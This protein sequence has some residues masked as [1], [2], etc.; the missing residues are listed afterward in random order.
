MTLAVAHREDERVVLDL[1][2]ERRPPFSP[3]DVVKE[4]TE[5]LRRYAITSVHGDRYGGEWPRERFDAHGITYE[6][7][8]LPKSELYRE[9][10]PLLNSGQVEL[11]DHQ[12]LLA[13]LLRLE[14]RTARGGRD[15]IDHAPGGHDDVAN[16]VAGALVGAPAFSARTDFVLAGGNRVAWPFGMEPQTARRGLII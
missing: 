5:T 1:V 12:R 3:E 2:R 11:L 14:R 16:A 10:L 4:F 7:A 13:Q 6:V 9:L 8:E 15:S